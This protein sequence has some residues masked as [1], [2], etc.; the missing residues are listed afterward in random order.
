MVIPVDTFKQYANIYMQQ[1]KKDL[2]EE[3]KAKMSLDDLYSKIEEGKL[4]ELDIII[5]ADVQGSVE[6]L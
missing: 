4:K 3:T 5:K 2:I 1:H 6:A